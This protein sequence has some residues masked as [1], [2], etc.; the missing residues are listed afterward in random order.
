MKEKRSTSPKTS[1]LLQLLH[2]LLLLALTVTSSAWLYYRNP[3]ENSLTA[4]AKASPAPAPRLTKRD[5]ALLTSSRSLAQGDLSQAELDQ[6]AD[7]FGHRSTPK[8]F[9]IDGPVKLGETVVADFYEAA[10]GEYIFSQFTPTLEK[11][12]DGSN[13]AVIKVE[14][15]SISLNGEITTRSNQTRRIKLGNIHTSL[16]IADGGTYATT[17]RLKAHSTPGTIHLSAQGNY[18]ARLPAD[19]EAKARP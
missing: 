14:S 16:S 6:L 15:H 10:P 12:P 18:T 17:L 19:P 4:K 9:V 8:S 13:V 1:Q 11:D 3:Q 7:H 2:L 5:G